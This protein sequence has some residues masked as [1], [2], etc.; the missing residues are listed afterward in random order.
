MKAKKA[1]TQQQV[2]RLPQRNHSVAGTP[3]YVPV[4]IS[5]LHPAA[6]SIKFG[7]AFHAKLAVEKLS[8]MLTKDMICDTTRL[9]A[10]Q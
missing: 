10:V 6:F 9:G 3:L 1:A 8:D 2:S 7:A 4:I 5:L